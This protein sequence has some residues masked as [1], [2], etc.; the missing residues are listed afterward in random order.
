MLEFMQGLFRRTKASA[1][2]LNQGQREAIVDLLVFGMYSDGKVS[3]AED[4][5]IQRRLEAMDW[6]AVE[7]VENYY[8]R[9]V[10]RVRDVMGYP[11]SRR[12]FL[13]GIG[14]RLGD[15]ATRERSFDLC[16]QLFLSDGEQSDAEQALERELRG[17]LGVSAR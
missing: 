11:E 8:D 3:L 4:Q 12:S 10:T 1:D 7:S 14:E 16:H 5:L 9:A 2:G 13:A 17:A 6:Q 15:A